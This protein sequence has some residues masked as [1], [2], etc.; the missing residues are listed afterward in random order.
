MEFAAE[1]KRLYLR[2]LHEKDSSFIL[3]LVNTKGWLEFIGDRKI[4]SLEDASEYI[5]M[6]LHNHNYNYT[7][8]EE[9]STH[10]PI[11]VVSFLQRDNHLY[12]D[13]G[14]ALLPEYEYQ[15]FAFEACHTFLQYL[16]E[17]TSTDIIIGIAKSNN[18]KSIKLLQKL[19]FTFQ[20][21]YVEFRAE[22]A[23]FQL[24]LDKEL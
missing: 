20:Y 6:I 11:G 16:K 10:I 7:V 15:G 17:H 8:I 13:L 23:V 12:P 21:N 5:A 2:P 24:N 4:Y 14:F 18:Q 9:K 19:G 1:T 3:E 22:Q